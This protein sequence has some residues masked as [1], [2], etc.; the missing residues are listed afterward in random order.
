M[1]DLSTISDNMEHLVQHGHA[2]RQFPSV[3]HGDGWD[4]RRWCSKISKLR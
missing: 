2:S 4:V 3:N 1:G